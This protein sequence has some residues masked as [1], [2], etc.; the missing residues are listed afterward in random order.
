MRPA[1]PAIALM[2]CPLVAQAAA[3]IGAADALA[4]ASSGEAVLVDARSHASF[5]KNHIEGSMMAAYQPYETGPRSPVLL[6]PRACS[7]IR[8]KT[9]IVFAH[10][11]K[12]PSRTVPGC[13]APDARWAADA[14]LA[15]LDVKRVCGVARVLFV[16]GGHPS[17]M[18]AG[19]RPGSGPHCLRDDKTRTWSCPPG[20]HGESILWSPELG[21]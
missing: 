5:A 20:M 2:L 8:G 21:T 1:L 9:A 6:N 17:L 10:D 13:P 11:M 14:A 12:D 4:L 7:A 18:D 15:Q 19:A 3:P 16:E